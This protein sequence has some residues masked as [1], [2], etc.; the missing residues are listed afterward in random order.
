MFIVRWVASYFRAISAVWHSFPGL[1][2]HFNDAAKLDNVQKKPDFKD[3]FPNCVQPVFFNY[4]ALMADVFKELKSLSEI[5][6]NQYAIL[7]K[8]KTS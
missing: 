7:S 2:E 1:S 4:L 6:Q 3:Y 8:P 5:L